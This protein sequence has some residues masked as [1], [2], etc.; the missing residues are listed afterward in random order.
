MP[1]LA[2]YDH[3]FSRGLRSAPVLRRLGDGQIALLESGLPRRV[4]GA[5]AVVYRFDLAPGGAIAVR[6]FL[7]PQITMRTEDVY[8]QALQKGVK[9]RKP[10]IFKKSISLNK[11][12]TSDYNII[13]SF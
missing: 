6:C 7:A 1:T 2:D 11:A 13:I 12:I 8:R 9:I 10:S 3:A 5:D 4:V